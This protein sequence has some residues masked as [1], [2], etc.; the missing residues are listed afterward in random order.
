[1][2]KRKREKLNIKKALRKQI[3]EMPVK[4]ILNLSDDSP[5]G[6][7]NEMATKIYQDEIRHSEIWEE[8]VKDHGKDKAEELIEDFR[9]YF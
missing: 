4:I 2:K 8:M 5:E 9:V 1:M 7:L 6:Q 3:Y